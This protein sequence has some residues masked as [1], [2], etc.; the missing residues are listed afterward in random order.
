MPGLRE[1]FATLIASP[2]VDLGRAAL[3][4]ARIGHPDLDPTPAL[5]A[6]DALAES[7]RPRLP[8]GSAPD[9]SAR[10]L[11]RYL[12]EECGFR[13]NRAD[14]YDPRNSF[15]NDVLERRTGIP[16]SLSVLAIEVGKRLGIRLEGVGFPGH[17]LVRVAMGASEAL[18]LDCFEGGSAVEQ[19]TLLARLRALADT[20]GGP[21]FGHVPPRFLE[22][23]APPGILARML[24]NLLRIYLER[25]EH[26]R[27]LA[28]VDLLLVL[29]PRS[30]EDVRT[31]ARLY[32]T[33]ECFASA[34][35][36]LRR[37]LA[38]APRADDAAA[39]REQLGR[40]ASDAP[41]LH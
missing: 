12:F 33:L 41:T 9:E 29:T 15:L 36:D 18:L 17:F 40:L 8:A 14:Y 5:R 25:E 30:A 27:A 32:E 6:L 7:L 38:L 4:I 10:L 16:I 20:S 2:S 22:P 21:E 39:V 3:E 26:E 1:R 35:D 34:A 11:A 37:Y 23:A 13:G 24:R 19:D 28:A 31:R